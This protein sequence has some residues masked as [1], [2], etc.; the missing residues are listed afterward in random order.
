MAADL[1][2]RHGLADGC[3]VVDLGCGMGGNLTLALCSP[4]AVVGVDLSPIALRHARA[5]GPRA[6]LVRADL[7]QPLPFA[8][9]SVDAVTIFNVLYHQ[10]IPDEG[11]ILSEMRRILR[12]AGILH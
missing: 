8:D 10:S 1:L 5:N 7:N 3:R 2:R 6:R 11:S 4:R 12:P 9:A